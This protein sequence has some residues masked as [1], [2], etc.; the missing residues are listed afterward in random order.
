[1]HINLAT[2]T[3]SFKIVYFGT[4]CCGK[5][6]NILKLS[7]LLGKEKPV[8]LANSDE[9]TIFFDFTYL[10]KGKVE[11]FN[12]RLNIYTIPG[13]SLYKVSRKL[14]LNGVDG[15]VFIADSSRKKLKEN[16]ESFNELKRY[17]SEMGISLKEIP[18]VIQYNKRDL[19]DAMPV[20]ELEKKLNAI[21]APYVESVAIEGKGVV[22]TIDA[23]TDLVIKRYKEHIK[24]TKVEKD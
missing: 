23:I 7:E 20:S 15:I 14:I 19:P 24:N 21:K 16:I 13:Q 11:D 2:K 1:M 22:E 10:D 8:V 5:T 12:V 4:G 9:R 3:V 18:I 17:L 6:T